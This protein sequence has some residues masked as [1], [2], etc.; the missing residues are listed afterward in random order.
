MTLKEEKSLPRS[1]E[2]A[3]AGIV[4]LLKAAGYYPAGHPSLE[5][6]VEETRKGFAPALANGALIVTVRR[7]GLLLEERPLAPANPLLKRLAA[8]LFARQV[9]SLTVLPELSPPDLLAFCRTLGK[10]PAD[11]LRQGGIASV[12]EGAR[13]RTV[14]VN[15]TDLRRIRER[16]KEIEESLEEP[17]E[18]ISGGDEESEEASPPEE[19]DGDDLLDILAKLRSEESDER[20]GQLLQELLPLLVLRLTEEFRYPVLDALEFIL[21]QG[22]APEVSAL[23]RDSSLQALEQLASDELVGFLIR[24]LGG[25]DLEAD[26][27]EKI[28]RLL[29][30]Y[31]RQAAP[32][33]MERLAEEA[34]PQARRALIETLVSLDD[35]AVPVMRDYLRDGRWFV[36][37]NAAAILGE[38]RRP[39]AISDFPPLLSHP[40]LR[41]R[42]EAVRALTRIGGPE[43]VSILLRT[44]E[45]EDPELSRQALLSIGA[46][47]DRSAVPVL[48][49]LVERPD[50]LQ[51]RVEIRKGAIR[52]LGEIGSPEA[53]PA[54][55][56]ILMRR[57]LWRRTVADEIRA[58]AATAL[59]EIPADGSAALEKALEDHSPEVARAAAQALKNL[60]KGRHGSG[61]K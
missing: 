3:L 34:D 44:V 28:Q 26:L 14:W 4:R 60:R 36:V 29:L 7:E 31:R 57:S 37:R 25:S 55:E 45:E 52:A 48:L 56:K 23:R 50:P 12:L 51:R 49:R 21:E 54:L 33:L 17:E 2:E 58:A 38:I 16:R 40:D 53:R 13:V 43:A 18:T 19:T 39:E 59:G 1:A 11:L 9:H 15:E 5:T 10:E 35:A 47:R 8:H 32:P 20:Y 41:V 6:A 27:K 24:F 46:L 42:R 30:F 61:T 22:R